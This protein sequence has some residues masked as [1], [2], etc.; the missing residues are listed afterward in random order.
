MAITSLERTNL[1]KLVVGM[2]N[3]APGAT[4]LNEVATIFEANGRDL[5]KV[6]NILAHSPAFTSIYTPALTN[7]EFASKFL[8][9][10]GLQGNTLA[11]DFVVGR[12]NAGVSKSDVMVQALVALNNTI[13]PAFADAKAIFLNKSLVAENFSVTLNKTTTDLMELQGAISTVTAATASVAAANAAN[14]ANTPVPIP[15]GITLTVGVDNLGGTGAAN[16]FEANVVQNS[17][18]L[19]SNTLGSGDKLNGGGGTDILDAKITAGAFV[20]GFESMPIQPETR[21]VEIIKLQAVSSGI[22]LAAPQDTQVY[23]NAKNMVDVTKISSTYSDADLVI[24]NMTTLTSAG[25]SRSVSDLTV[26]ME[27]SGNA[28]TRWGASDLAVYFDQDYLVPGVR[29]S[30]SIE[31]RI[32]NNLE[33][34]TVNRP[35]TAFEGVSFTVGTTVVI[36]DI[37]PAVNALTGPAAYTALIGLIQARLTALNI[38]DVTVTALPVRTAVFT[39]DLPGGFVQ[40]HN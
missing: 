29:N 30:S 4:Y 18:G 24:Q 35:L 13:S 22:S 16:T 17:L 3:A 12:L 36:V 33:L 34:A 26:G 1:I 6:A 11:T 38:T 31:I 9:S 32:V 10:F 14:L 21:S 27:Y 19:Q 5:G 7:Q 23:V 2:F 37:P 28:D 40:G 25:T 39:D 15:T 8:T 20:G